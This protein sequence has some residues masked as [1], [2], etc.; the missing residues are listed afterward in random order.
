MLFILLNIAFKLFILKY[1]IIIY[2][3][4]IYLHFKDNNKNARG[5]ART[6]DPWLIRPK[7]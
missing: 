1:I 4:Y 6:C 5:R 2:Y 3:L 7:L